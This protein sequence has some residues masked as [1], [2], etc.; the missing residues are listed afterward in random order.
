[1]SCH[2]HPRRREVKGH[3]GKLRGAM[4]EEKLDQAPKV[5]HEEGD[6]HEQQ[7]ERVLLD[8]Y[9]VAKFIMT[10]LVMTIVT[11]SAPSVVVLRK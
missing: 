3:V 8:R 9:V 5:R 11:I 6:G 1:M 10:T 7:I 2:P 4:Q